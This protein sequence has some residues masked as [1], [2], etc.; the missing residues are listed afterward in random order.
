L[1][2]DDANLKIEK[3]SGFSVFMGGFLTRA[4]LQ[5][6]PN[7]W[8]LVS[9]VFVGSNQARSMRLLFQFVVVVV[10]VVAAVCAKDC[11]KLTNNW[12]ASSNFFD[13]FNF[14]TFDDPTHGFVDYVDSSTGWNEGLIKYVDGKVYI[15][16]DHTNVVD[17]SSR[18]RKSIRLSSKTQVNGRNL[19]VI[20]LE[21]MPTTLGSA[22]PAGCATW[23]AFWTCG[24][25]WPNN[26]EIDII[27]YVNT[28]NTVLTTLHTSSSCDQS[29]ESTSTFTGHWATT[30]NGA[31]SDNCDVNAGDQYS[32]QG[33]GIISS[34]G[35]TVGKSFN[36]R[37]TGGV[38]VMEW[39]TDAEIRAFFFSRDKIPG[40]LLAKNP[41]P[42]SW[43]TPY[44][45]FAIGSNSQCSSN[46]FNYH[47]I[48]FDT[49]FCG[50]WAGSVF[51]SLCSPQ[52]DCTSFVRNN[53][54]EFSESYWLLNYVDTYEACY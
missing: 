37:G 28:D 21:H 12:S 30:I 44:A 17:Y 50:D 24:S 32:N 45:R 38:Y 6:P 4:R 31:N 16:V 53:P 9:V 19:V 40:D 33:C 52:S 34:E 7:K 14:E 5:S 13:A 2:G 54:A 36:S 20:D 48:I 49:T 35:S 27:E 8:F 18:G 22:A 26:G 11:Y 39:D 46:H 41:N 47:N 42:N 15:G 3:N 51:A 43:G 25:D 23:P 29:A 1:L 10:V